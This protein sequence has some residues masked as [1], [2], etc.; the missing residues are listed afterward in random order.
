M[1]L[2]VMRAEPI[3]HWDSLH[4]VLPLGVGSGGIT[5]LERMNFRLAGCHLFEQLCEDLF[6]DILLMTPANL[7][8]WELT[9]TPTEY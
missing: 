2:L 5:S 6:L 8:V 7:V 3:W 9:V 1:D 4:L